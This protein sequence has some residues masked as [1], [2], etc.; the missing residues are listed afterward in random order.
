LTYAGLPAWAGV[1]AAD[2]AG[3]ESGVGRA[4]GDLEG[5]GV[6]PGVAER[7][8]GAVL[9]LGWEV[10][11][12]P[13][14]AHAPTSSAPSAS[15]STRVWRRRLGVLGGGSRWPSTIDT[16]SNASSGGV[17]ASGVG[18][19]RVVLQRSVTGEG[20]AS[21]C[22]AGDCRTGLVCVRVSIRAVVRSIDTTLDDR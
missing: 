11:V 3:E 2:E 8:L 22:E 4:L 19:V 16:P 6:A 15:A 21:E 14:P 20:V 9:A 7:P 17:A 12:T 1:S 13:G 5:L 10:D 18:A